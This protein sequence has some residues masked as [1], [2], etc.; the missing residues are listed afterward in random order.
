MDRSTP[1]GWNVA[2]KLLGWANDTATSDQL[3]ALRTGLASIFADGALGS[4]DILIGTAEDDN[5]TSGSGDCVTSRSAGNDN[6][7]KMAA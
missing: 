6:C 1:A 3:D 2:E 5:L 7:W 4:P